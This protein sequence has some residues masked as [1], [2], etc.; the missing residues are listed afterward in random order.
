MYIYHNAK[1]YFSIQ[2]HINKIVPKK[3]LLMFTFNFST[4]KDMDDFMFVG[5]IT[6]SWQP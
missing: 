5:C 1:Q 4:K 2:G 6:S 3:L